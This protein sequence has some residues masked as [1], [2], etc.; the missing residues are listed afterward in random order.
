MF[1]LFIVLSSFSESSARHQTK[2]L[3]SNDEPCM[4]RPILIDMNP[5]ELEYY[6]F[7]NSLNKCTGSCNVLSPKI[8]VLKETKDT[9][10][11]AFN[12]ITNKDEAKAM[13]E[14]ILCQVKCKFNSTTYNSKQKWNNK[15]CHCECK[16]Y[17]KCK[18]YYSW[19]TST[20]ICENSKYL[21]SI[22]DTSV[23]VCGEIIFVMDIMSTKKTNIIVT[24]KTNT[25]ATNAMSSASINCLSKKVRDCYILHTV[26]LVT[27]LLLIITTIYHY[28]AKQKGTI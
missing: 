4:V 24:K 8:R 6:P 2:V 15:T 26:L 21:K 16:N 18:K 5:V 17:R 23:T 19:N 10:F 12:M 3:F 27:I 25:T 13:T 9:N 22:A 1:R 28:Y 14:H 11:K 7:I 20:C